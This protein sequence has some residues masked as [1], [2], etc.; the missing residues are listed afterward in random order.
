MQLEIDPANLFE[1][2]KFPRNRRNKSTQRPSKKR[3]LSSNIQYTSTPNLHNTANLHAFQRSAADTPTPIP[4][5][6]IG[7][8]ILKR[9][10]RKEHAAQTSETPTSHP[11]HGAHQAPAISK[12]CRISIC[13]VPE[14]TLWACSR[15]FRGLA[16][17]RTS[18]LEKDS[19]AP[20]A[21]C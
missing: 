5:T 20:R 10:V 7:F 4:Q 13:L 6:C 1:K 21:R 3:R 2:P 9:S 11:R 14:I 15:G 17:G 8:V 12:L 19:G 18:G 16:S